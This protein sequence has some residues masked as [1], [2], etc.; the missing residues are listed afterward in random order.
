MVNYIKENSCCI[1]GH[2]KINE[3]INL[4]NVLLDLI[5]NRNVSV[6]NFGNYGEFNDLCYNFLSTLKA[7][8]KQIK[9]VLYSLNNEIAFTFEEA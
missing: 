2:R 8:G 6:F 7:S 4:Y 1:I 9:L 3:N 5:E